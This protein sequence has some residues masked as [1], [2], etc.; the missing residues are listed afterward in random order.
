MRTAPHS[1]ALDLSPK[2][3]PQPKP[4]TASTHRHEPHGAS[5]SLVSSASIFVTFSSLVVSGFFPFLAPRILCAGAQPPPSYLR[6]LA[7]STPFIMVQLPDDEGAPE[8]NSSPEKQTWI[9]R[10]AAALGA[11]VALFLL[12]N[13]RP[14]WFVVAPTSDNVCPLYE[15]LAPA[16]F[17]ED[18]STVLAILHDAQFRASA[19]RK[20]SNAVKVDTQ[21]GDSQPGVDEAPELWI[22]FEKFHKYLNTTFATV[23]NTAKVS[24]VNTYGVVIHWEGSDKSLKPVLLTA[25]QD[26]VPV[27][28]DTLDKWT[29][30]PLS[31]HYDG[32]YVWGRGSSDCKNVLVAIL[33]SMEILLGRGFE[34]RRS[35]VVA[36]GFDEEAL[37]T[38]GAA[39]IGPFLEKEFGHNGF[40]VLI[41]EGPGLTKDTISG[42]LVAIAGTGEKGYMDVSVELTTPGGHSSVPPDHT[43]IGI[44]SEVGF[45]LEK[46]PYSPL[47][48]SQNP[49]L[50]YLQCVARH[51]DLPRLQKKA[52][53]R[54]G[55]DKFANKKVVELMVKNPMSRYLIQTSQALDVVVGGEK[56]NALPE[57][58][59][60]VVNHRVS[61]ETSL[62]TIMANIQSQVE[63]IAEK[64]DLGLTVLGESIRPATEKGC[65]VVGYQSPPTAT[66]PVSPSNDTV[67]SEVAGVTRH[68][69]EQLVYPNLTHP[70]VLVPGMMPANTDTRHYWNLTKNIYRYSPYFSADL[71][72]DNRIHL[73]DERVL[74]DSHLQLTAFFYEY[75]QAVN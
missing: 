12:I 31:G 52:M 13:W 47:L 9:K 46:H 55:F 67:W 33:E 65:F 45:E 53:L 34:P 5:A 20:L 24:Y 17:L 36:L 58:V 32:Q 41:D 14:I 68:V 57:H 63:K 25:H 69:F 64:H 6:I 40:H 7:F 28:L 70:L 23:M 60:L 29:H 51:G 16:S 11:V 35:V 59:R 21:I 18:N 39:H 2:R 44:I 74:V 42:Q 15:P 73:V 61:V 19:A 72:K 66:A 43:S 56:A 37:G 1:A 22:Q 54:A 38:H 10:A 26:T 3:P 49:M 50:G 75:I 8:V 62:E 27:Q 30:P 48:T 71:V 4:T